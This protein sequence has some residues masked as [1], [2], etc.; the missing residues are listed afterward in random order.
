[1][2][3]RVVGLADLRN[4]KNLVD[5]LKATWPNDRPPLLVLN[6]VALP[7]RP[8]IS[9][10]DF[11]QALELEPKAIIEFDAQLFGTSRQ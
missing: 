5:Q 3:A 10:E 9:V 4:A 11:A 1:M 2:Q 8:E 7:K 6:Q